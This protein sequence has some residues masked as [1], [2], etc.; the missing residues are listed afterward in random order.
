MDGFKGD[1]H[2]H[3]NDGKD[4]PTFFKWI[5]TLNGPGV[6]NNQSKPGDC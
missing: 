4:T 3:G 2:P 5:A 1:N 6:I